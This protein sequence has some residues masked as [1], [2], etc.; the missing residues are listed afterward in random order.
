M[1]A[2]VRAAGISQSEPHG[3]N[4][5]IWTRE[6]SNARHIDQKTGE[7]RMATH[8][9][10]TGWQVEELA[11][12]FQVNFSAIR[13]LFAGARLTGQPE[14]RLSAT[15][16]TLSANTLTNFCAVGNAVPG[17]REPPPEPG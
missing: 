3:V 11:A 16:R 14:S 15:P 7:N 1:R 13:G 9:N 10:C 4:Q 17:L 5:S 2:D 12:K 8:T 6:N